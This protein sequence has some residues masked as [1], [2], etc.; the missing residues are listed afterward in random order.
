MDRK[1]LQS[2]DCEGQRNMGKNDRSS[3][4][5][6]NADQKFTLIELLVVIAIIAIL[7]GMLLPALQNARAKAGAIRCTSQVKQWGTMFQ[8]YSSDSE[9]WLVSA[10]IKT[11]ASTVFTWTQNLFSMGYLKGNFMLK[12]NGSEE[13]G[14]M[15]CPQ[16]KRLKNI[17][18]YLNLGLTHSPDYNGT[19]V[20]GDT[21]GTCFY[22]KNNQIAKASQ[23]LYLIDGWTGEANNYT[24]GTYWCSR[25]KYRDTEGAEPDFRH[26]SAANALFVDGHVE[27]VKKTEPRAQRALQ[28][29]QDIRTNDYF[30]NAKGTP[31]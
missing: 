10:G 15:Q 14:L 4:N 18:Y 22:Y 17:S 5:S 24:N 27:T 8:M 31:L 6:A 21:N 1:S 20:A 16:D 11:G 25:K 7:A 26:S 29:G 3:C 9:G 28:T 2:R 12:N 13:R 30:W 19:A 23:A